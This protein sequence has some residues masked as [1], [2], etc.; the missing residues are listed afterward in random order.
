MQAFLVLSFAVI[1]VISSVLG[2]GVLSAY[3]ARQHHW[4]W[5]IPPI[6]FV[7]LGVIYCLTFLVTPLEGKLQAAFLER[8]PYEVGMLLGL[9]LLW[10]Q[11]LFQVVFYWRRRRHSPVMYV[12]FNCLTIG[13]VVN[14]VSIGI[15]FL[16]CP[17]MMVWSRDPTTF[18]HVWL[19]E[20]GWLTYFSLAFMT[21]PLLLSLR[22]RLGLWQIRHWVSGMSG[23]FLVSWWVYWLNCADIVR[24]V[25]LD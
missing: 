14:L 21:L 10:I 4:K 13:Q 23:L 9:G 12:I 6:T 18:N 25:V 24:S 22:G 2:I 8:L 1:L 7:T 3:L 5:L 16:L 15:I 20:L 11:W 17:T 19:F